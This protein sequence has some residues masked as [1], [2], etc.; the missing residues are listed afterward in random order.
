MI[1]GFMTFTSVKGKA[2]N[3]FVAGRT[4][5]LWIVSFTVAA[6]SLDSNA[7]LGNVDLSYKIQFW[8]GVVLPL[9]L[10]LSLLLNGIILADK[11]HAENVLT[12][13]DIFARRYGSLVE[14][15]ISIICITSFLFLLAGNL[16]GIAVILSYLLNM[17]NAAATWTAV[18]IIW[19]YTVVGGLFSVAYT[20]VAQGLIGWTGCAVAAF[21]IIST[22]SPNAAPPSVGFPG[23][24]YPNQ[25]ICDMYSGVPCSSDSNSCC[26]NETLALPTD[27]GAYPI[28]DK[29]IFHDQMTNAQALT[30]FPNAIMLN[31]STIFV[32]MF[33]NL[34]ALDFQARCMASKTATT[35]RL[36]CI[37]GGCATLFFGIPFA[38]LGSITRVLYGPDSIHAE[39]ET[40]SCASILGVPSCGLWLPDPN[41]FLKLLTHDVPPFI[42]G[43]C[44]VGVIS[45]SMSTADGAILAMGTV[46]ANNIMRNI[47]WVSDKNLLNASRASTLPF[48]VISGLIATFNANKTGSLLV[49][50]FD[51]VLAAAVVPLLGCFYTRTKPSPIAAV[52]SIFTGVIVRV[53]LE[54]T[55]PKDGSLILPF[56]YPEFLNVG[57]LASSTTTPIWVDDPNVPKWD[58]I[59][60]PCNET[61]FD[62]FTGVDSLAAPLAALLVFS[63]FQFLDR[64]GTLFPKI[65]EL[66]WMTPYNKSDAIDARVSMWKRDSVRILSEHLASQHTKVSASQ[67]GIDDIKEVGD[68]SA[69]DDIKADDLR[70]KEEKPFAE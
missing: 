12:L 23:Y 50:A 35:A 26:Y 67:G 22:A 44:L 7:L 63:I 60:E 65:R 42:G 36:G 32:L 34:A 54:F 58:P 55:L 19:A 43:W 9:G 40:N 39:F 8:D 11:I 4:L 53:T 28:G 48:A 49:V 29:Q 37:I 66:A 38:Y 6:Q 46:F 69:S 27:N 18:A 17:S 21:Y 1:M 62:D 31:W 56:P 51:V 2:E 41:A 24:M 64:N 52:A 3:F 30:P 25:E 16:V 10:G 15:V 14:L 68:E 47:A 61:R 5:P 70:I 20:D 33:G 59:T 45:A 57:N 13:P